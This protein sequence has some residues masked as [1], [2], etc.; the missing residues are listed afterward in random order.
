MGSISQP[1]KTFSPGSEFKGKIFWPS[2]PLYAA[3]AEQYASSTYGITR[4]LQ[5]GAILQ[6]SETEDIQ[7]LVKNAKD[8]GIAVAIRTGGHQYCG[9]S[10]TTPGNVQLDLSNT[11]KQDGRDRNISGP[12][13]DG[14]KYLNVSVSWSLD[15]TISYLKT[16]GVFM[17]TGQCITVYL[18]GH[19]QSGGYG[20]LAR[21]FGLLGDYIRELTVV[22]YGGEVQT[23]S[24]ESNPDLFYGLLGGSPGNFGVVTHA[25][26]EVQQDVNHPNSQGLWMACHFTQARYKALLDLLV[27]K[28]EDASF[29]RG[30]DLTV[31]VYDA[32]VDLHSLWPGLEDEL[33]RQFEDTKPNNGLDNEGKQ[34]DLTKYAFPVIL[35]YAQWVNIGGDQPAFSSDL[36]T[37]I[38]STVDFELRLIWD[39]FTYELR[40]PFSTLGM[41]EIASWWLF[42]KTREFA[43]PYDK[44][45]NTTNNLVDTAGWSA[46]FAERI[47]AG[48]DNNDLFICSQLQV[49]GGKASMFQTNAGNGTAYTFRDAVLGGTWDAFYANNALNVAQDWQATNDAGMQ[50]YFSTADRRV[51]WGS[52]GDWTMSTAWPAYYDEATYNKLRG[53]RSKWDPNGTFTP[54]PF[55]V[56]ALPKK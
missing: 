31:N 20:M 44:R 42:H 50:Q 48:L 33:Q 52:Y 32:G 11:F 14:K 23:A 9:A 27:Q 3:E 54:N 55:C 15:E 30:Y 56:E 29:P 39:N 34:L 8:Q 16:N 38:K 41:S 49:Y 7:V 19:M 40:H 2:D 26:I 21:S 18:G 22:D 25:K 36:F 10:S 46:W 35:V 53:L 28:S 5:P 37:K 24:K 47:Q 12:D 13:A 17:P 6:P 45:T 4:D 1:V 51:L 43:L